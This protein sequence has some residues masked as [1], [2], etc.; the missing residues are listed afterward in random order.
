MGYQS[1]DI[2]GFNKCNDK[3]YEKKMIIR[4]DKY[5]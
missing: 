2:G 4:S 3:F 1:K 5:H